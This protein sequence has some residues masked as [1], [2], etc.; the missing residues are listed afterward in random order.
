[1]KA[2]GKIIAPAL[3]HEAE[4]GNFVV[5]DPKGELAGTFVR[6]RR[7]V[8]GA[9]HVTIINPLVLRPNVWKTTAGSSC[10]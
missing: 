9:E 8:G 6:C 4:R 1:M 3:L 10:R 2:K 7:K 5:I